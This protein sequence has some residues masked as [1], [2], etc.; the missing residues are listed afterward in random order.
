MPTRAAAPPFPTLSVDGLTAAAIA[1]HV[2]GPTSSFV[3]AENAAA[4]LPSPPPS[5]LASP[6][7]AAAAAASAPAA[8]PLDRYI[9]RRSTNS[10]RKTSSS[11]QP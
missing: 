9:C 10:F 2:K 4:L 5:F 1:S 11:Q 7:T 3:V 6:R 8:S